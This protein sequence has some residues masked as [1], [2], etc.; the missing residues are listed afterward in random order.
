MERKE[1]GRK[2]AGPNLKQLAGVGASWS[3]GARSRASVTG[4]PQRNE[5]LK[6]VRSS[7]EG[8]PRPSLCHLYVTSDPA[9]V[10]ES[11]WED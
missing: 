10:T 8:L 5:R 7:K 4:W 11:P 6:A 3:A 2:N 9:L 1:R